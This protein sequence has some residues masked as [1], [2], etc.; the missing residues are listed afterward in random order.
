M[1][2]TIFLAKESRAEEHRIALIPEDAAALIE[3]G[4]FVCVESNA[5]LKAG[6]KDE[7][8]QSI[9][10]SI[11]KIN[12]NKLSS[13]IDA[14]KNITM[15]VRA[16]R[17]NR[18][19][20]KLES[21]AIKWGT[22]LIGAFDPL[23]SDSNHVAEYHHAGI[24]AYSI[25]Q[26]ILSPTDPMNVLAAM[27][28]FTGEL[29]LKDARAKCKNIVNKVVIIGL[30]EVGKSALAESI[31]LKLPTFVIVDNNAQ[32]KELETI[33]VSAYLNDSSLSIQAQQLNICSKISDADIVITTARMASQKAPLLIPQSTLDVMKPGAVI[34]DM[35]ISEGG[36][37]FGSKHD[38]T[39]RTERNVHI[40]NVSG[41]P[42]LMP[43]AA[44][45]LWSK[46]SLHFMSRLAEKPNSI[47]LKP[48]R[49]FNDSRHGL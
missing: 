16:K 27:G 22:I 15:I 41:Y 38:Q 47:L 45:A 4:H 23:E 44:S 14:F 5:G 24:L 3:K 1:I 11:V 9:G 25:D 8:Y 26:A 30:G 32:A 17:P 13:Y 20:E 40:T 21:Q 18:R 7:L 37:V 35:P 19:R 29:V 36:N 10:A 28:R 33:G 48:L 31:K 34:V 2:Y 6:Y 43:H 39:I 46:A 49:I 42:K 12:E